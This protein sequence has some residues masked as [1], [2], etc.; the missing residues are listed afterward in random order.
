MCTQ[1]HQSCLTLGILLQLQHLYFYP[2]HWDRF[3]G[4]GY[5]CSKRVLHKVPEDQYHLRISATYSVN[6]NIPVNQQLYLRGS[7]WSPAR[8]DSR[9]SWYRSSC[10]WRVLFSIYHCISKETWSNGYRQMIIR[11]ERIEV[12]KL[13]FN[14]SRIS[15]CQDLVQC[16][17]GS[18]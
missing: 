18:P 3:A 2:D 10:I 14:D 7:T 6:I 16:E 17:S 4:Y 12:I 8:R 15:H 1:N 13:M 9:A 5:T 11:E